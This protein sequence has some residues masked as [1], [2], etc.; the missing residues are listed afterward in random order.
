[1]G[2]WHGG[3][4]WDWGRVDIHGTIYRTVLY[5]ND[6][7]YV[8]WSILLRTVGYHTDYYMLSLEE[9]IKDWGPRTC[10]VILQ[11]IEI[12]ICMPILSLNK[13][14]VYLNDMTLLFYWF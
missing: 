12:Y 3:H 6:F 5:H 13:I 11:C 10:A 1:M 14:L 4:I 8:I 2:Q 7:W 9:V